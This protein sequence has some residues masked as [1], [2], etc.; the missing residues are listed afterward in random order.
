LRLD[1]LPSPG[2]VKLSHLLAKGEG[3][4]AKV[5]LV[6]MPNGAVCRVS[7]GLFGLCG[8]V[9]IGGGC[10]HVRLADAYGVNLFV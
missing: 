4:W 9:F 2:F 3:F 5:R 10:S 6:E 8:G 1:V 7:S